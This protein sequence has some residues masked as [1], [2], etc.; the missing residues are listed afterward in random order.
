MAQKIDSIAAQLIMPRL[1]VDTY[2][3]KLDYKNQIDKLVALGVCGFCIFNGI[4]EIARRLMAELQAKSEIPLIFTADFEYGL[5]MRLSEGNEFPH[6]WAIGETYDKA[7]AFTIGQAI[8][9]ESK[10]LGVDWVFAPVVDINDNPENPIINIRAF[11]DNPEKVSAFGVEFIKGMQSEKVLATAKHFP[12]HGSTAF[13]SHIK[14]PYLNKSI[15]EIEMNELFPFKSAIENDVKSIMVGHLAVEALDETNTPASLSKP[16]IDYLLNVLNFKGIIITDALDMGAVEDVENNALKSILSGCTIALMPKDPV[17]QIRKIIELAISNEE[18]QNLIHSDYQKIIRAKRWAGLIPHFAKEKQV[19]QTFLA[20]QKS[21]LKIAYQA[22][23]TD[24][25]KALVPLDDN[26]QFA[27]FAIIEKDKDIRSASRY[28][29]MLAQASENDC[30]FGYINADITDDEIDELRTN[31]SDSEL[32]IFSIFNKVFSQSKADKI[33][34][35]IQKMAHGKKTI[36]ITFG[37]P[38]YYT[39]VHS[40]FKIAAFSDTFPSLA[41]AILVLSGREENF[42]TYY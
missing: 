10:D 37:N 33:N 21:A 29:T 20:N 16:I 30:D 24:G 11:G 32:I 40:D 38:N 26:I 4:T 22:L 7:N 18:F 31:I 8:A 6:A 14:L 39:F 25:N 2:Y 9:K 17:E 35:I 42:K 28:F 19:E 1:D 27:G 41:A 23:K 12:G 15:S 34:E 5:P 36:S 3:D 13:D